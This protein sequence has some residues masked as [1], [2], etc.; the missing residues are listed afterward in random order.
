[1]GRIVRREVIGF[2]CEVRGC[3]STMQ[4]HPITPAESTWHDQVGQ[5]SEM[6]D[7]G[8]AVVIHPRIRTYCPQHANRAWKCSCRTH[9]DRRHLCTVH[10]VEAR[11]LVWD[12]SEVPTVVEQF[13]AVI[14]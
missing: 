5:L 6:V 11:N 3:G 10:D 9:P 7:A 12:S 4:A 2:R 1:M 8:W 13:L 14:I